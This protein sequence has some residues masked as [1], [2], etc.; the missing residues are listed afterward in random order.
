LILKI[1]DVVSFKKGYKQIKN[2]VPKD[3][4]ESTTV[5]RMVSQ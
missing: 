3:G 4:R 2:T 5:F 1:R